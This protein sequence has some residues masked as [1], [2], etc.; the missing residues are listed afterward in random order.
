MNPAF[1]HGRRAGYVADGERMLPLIK[2]PTKR[3]SESSSRA[4]GENSWVDQWALLTAVFKT[5]GEDRK[6]TGQFLEI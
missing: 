1:H 5:G 4:I 2:K 3:C 6:L